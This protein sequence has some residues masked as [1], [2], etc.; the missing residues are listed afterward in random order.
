MK[1]LKDICVDH[2]IQIGPI[3]NKKADIIQL[4]KDK[5]G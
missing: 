3:K 1:E 5:I 4:I 2:G